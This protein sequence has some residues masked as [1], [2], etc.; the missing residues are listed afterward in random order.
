MRCRASYYQQFD[1]DYDLPVPAHGFG[2]WQSA[3][4]DLNPASTA[5]ISMH[6]WD[7]RTAARFPGVWRSVEYIPRSY[8]I[9]E[10][11]LPPLFAAV[12]AS[13]LPL[14]HVVSGGGNYYRHL[15]G[16]ARTLD[17]SG[18]SPAPVPPLTPDPATS[19][20]WKLRS[21]RSW[22]GT[23][24]WEDA[25]RFLNEVDF[26]DAARPVGDEWIAEDS[27]QLAAVCRHLGIDHLIYTGFA[28]DACLLSSPGGMVDL[29]RCGALCSVVRDATTAVECKESAADEWHKQTAVWRVGSQ[30]GLVFEA[31][32]LIA[33]LEGRVDD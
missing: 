30:L 21:E 11:V 22:R 26:L 18:P 25:S 2:G 23:H 17:V 19:A 8:A 24:N 14:L 27:W 32:D 20:L 10:T 3:L 7:C 9:A 1:A 28:I 4:V 13:S 5:V 15:P 12:R 29:S 16:F 6:A 33:A 31:G